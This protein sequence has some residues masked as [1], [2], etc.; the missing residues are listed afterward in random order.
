MKDAMDVYGIDAIPFSRKIYFYFFVIG[1]KKY[2]HKESLRFVYSNGETYTNDIDPQFCRL[3]KEIEPIDVCTFLESYKGDLLPQLLDVNDKFLVYQY[4]DGSLVT[5]INNQEFYQLKQHHLSM[6]LTPFYN[7]MTYNLLR[8]GGIKLID[9]KHFEV[10]DN[11]PFFV[12]MYNKN[13]NINTLYIEQGTDHECVYD[14]LRK[15]YPVDAAVKH[16]Y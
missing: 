6:D 13:T 4:E 9:L 5:D 1:N 3:T 15:D 16:I 11:K 7:S 10:R 14:H 12:Y 2:I 8:N